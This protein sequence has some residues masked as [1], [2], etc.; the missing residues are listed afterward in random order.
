MF[1]NNPIRPREDNALTLAVQAIFPTIQGEGPYAGRCATFIRL[2]GC[3]LAC[4]FC[5]TD[6][7]SKI[8]NHM[9]VEAI[10]D[11]VRSYPE[12]MQKLVVLTGGEPLRQNIALL[13][14]MLLTK[15]GSKTEVVQLETA[16]T[17]WNQRL[18]PW[19]HR[20]AL[21]IVCSPKTPQIHPEVA[22]L[23]HDWKYIISA[24]DAAGDDGLPHQ[25]TQTRNKH[26]TQQIW[27]RPGGWLPADV[28]WLS[29][30]DES[31]IPGL[32]GDNPT[33]LNANNHM[34]VAERAMH[35]G[36]RVSLQMHKIMGVE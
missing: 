2:A 31:Q 24:R 35:F 27:R 8:D 30:M 18:N 36:Y 29:P 4:H 13:V 17:L 34:A 1:G 5:D 23:C 9:A 26:L 7:E 25:G 22:D 12:H 28:V 6:F 21:R 19:V 15:A 3:N 10:V 33:R 16:G 32:V 14:E 11:Q 20:A